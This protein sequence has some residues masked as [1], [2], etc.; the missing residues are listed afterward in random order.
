MPDQKAPASAAAPSQSLTEMLGLPWHMFELR[1]VFRK[2]AG[3]TFLNDHQRAV[4]LSALEL[5]D[6]LVAALADLANAVIRYRLQTTPQ[7]EPASTREAFGLV[8]EQLIKV[9][10]VLAKARG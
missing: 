6:D 2:E 9:D 3:Y 4:M 7:P 8:N 1:G 5:H 10:A